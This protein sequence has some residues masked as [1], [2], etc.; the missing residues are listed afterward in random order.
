[1]KLSAAPIL[2]RVPRRAGPRRFRRRHL[3]VGAALVAGATVV[4][5][6]RLKVDGA[7]APK[8][9]LVIR[10][11]AASVQVDIDGRASGRTSLFPRLSPGDHQIA[12]NDGRYVPATYPVHIVANHTT[13]ITVLA[14]RKT[15]IVRAIHPSFPGATIQ[16]A[17]FLDDARVVL[18]ETIP[19][20]DT[21]QAWILDRTGTMTAIGTGDVDGPVDLA[22]DG[23]QVA[24][25]SGV[26]APLGSTR[27]WTE[28]RL[29]SVDGG[30]AERRYP[31]PVQKDESATDLSW[32]P[33]GYH[34]L[35][36]T[37]QAGAN[38]HRTR[39]LWL[40]VR[41]GTI[42]E[43]AVIPTDTVNG[44]F[45]WSSD[46]RHAAFLTRTGSLTSLCLLDVS[47]KEG[48]SYL[49]DLASGASIPLPFPPVAWSPDGQRL[50]Y[51]APSSDPSSPTGWLFGGKAEQAIDEASPAHPF[52]AQVIASGGGTPVWRPDGMILATEVGRDGSLGLRELTSEKVFAEVGTIPVSVHGA[53]A[54]R[55]DARHARAI[56]V[57]HAASAA[58]TSANSYWLV[59]FG[60][61][62][63]R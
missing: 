23:R 33:N 14:W 24:V 13:T 43:L 3:L 41:R 37:Q 1:M 35:V 29:E 32:A 50:L 30:S 16:N 12:V 54:I 21:Y 48:V 49:T 27:R 46:G 51:A 18:I 11:S 39:F 56:V 40:D 19:T 34:L 8:G 47:V 44:S 63:A 26:V 60:T 6:T 17:R 15:P 28:V 2:P 45:A 4:G 20:G 38:A 22:P 7:N 42:A 10:S 55:W 62:A 58:G 5:A 57:S 59:D 25:L 52:G 36:V 53:Y 31:L 61:E 9:T